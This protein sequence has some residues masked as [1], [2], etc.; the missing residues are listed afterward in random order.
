[1]RWNQDQIPSQESLGLSALVVPEKNSG[2]VENA[3][4]QGYRVYV[5]VEAAAVPGFG[6]IS[7]ISLSV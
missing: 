6:S 4:A 2:A 5:E 1:M 7:A 3:L